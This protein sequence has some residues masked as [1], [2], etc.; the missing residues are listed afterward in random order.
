MEAYLY[1]ISTFFANL[2]SY[3]VAAALITLG[4]FA[5]LAKIVDL[6]V[7]RMLKSFCRKS[8]VTIEEK[9]LAI[10][11]HPIWVVMLLIGASVV[12]RWLDLLPQYNYVVRGVFRTL[13]LLVVLTTINRFVT[14]LFGHWSESRE[15]GTE[16]INKIEG[17]AQ[18]ALFLVGLALLLAIWR[19]NPAPFIISAGVVGIV[20][21]IAAKYSLSNLFGG[22]SLA[23]DKPF[24]V[25]DYIVLDTG[26]R[27][28]VTWVGFRST[29]ILTRDD[30]Q[31]TI[32][33]AILSEA[34]I[35][36]ES[37]PFPRYRIRI[38]VGVAYGTNIDTAE[39]TLLEVARSNPKISKFPEPRIRFREFGNSALEL[40]LLCWAKQ[41][42]DRGV[43]IHQMGKTIYKTFQ[44]KGITIPFPQQHIYVHSS[45]GRPEPTSNVDSNPK[46]DD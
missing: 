45:A 1:Q 36:N 10:I 6:S 37:A 18:I 22:I 8:G 46:A 19:I 23:L 9:L 20:V 17:A 41:P 13:A 5:V 25:G 21:A 44:E 31:I 29:R 42:Q 3:P 26:E 43:V 33:N 38:K 40:E 14:T 12:F 11:H 35:I 24:K 16:V 4:F 30:V 39:E 34:K 2:K 15:G 7:H 28:K 32:P 27:G